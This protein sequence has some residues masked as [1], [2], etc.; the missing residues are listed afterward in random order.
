MNTQKIKILIVDDE[1][2]FRQT[3]A[4]RLNQ[5]GFAAR[6]ASGGRECLKLMEDEP[7]DVVLLDLKMTELSGLEVLEQIK[8]RWPEAEVI[9][10]TGHASPDTGIQVLRLGALDYLLKPAPIEELERKI[11]QAVEKQACRTG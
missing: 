8:K 2:L 6:E 10:L 11:H 1:Q 3:L 5:R 7:F 4:E 9:M